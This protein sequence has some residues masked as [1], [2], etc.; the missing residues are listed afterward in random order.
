MLSEKPVPRKKR[1]RM[2]SSEMKNYGICHHDHT[3]G[4][5]WLLLIIVALLIPYEQG[6]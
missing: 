1:R 3:T 4:A 5:D 2:C 6:G